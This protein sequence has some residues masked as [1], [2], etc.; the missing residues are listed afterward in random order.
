LNFL[1]F[2][3]P[4]KGI[5]KKFILIFA[6]FMVVVRS[7]A[8]NPLPR[9]GIASYY[10]KR[11]NHHRTASGERLSNDSFTAA[12]RTYPFGTYLKVTNLKNDRMTIV[13][14]NDRG[15]H[16]RRRII[17]LSYAAARKIR[18]MNCGLAEVRVELASDEEIKNKDQLNT[19][20]LAA[21]ITACIKPVK[22]V[23][24]IARSEKKYVI[25]AGIFRLKNSAYNLEKYLNHKNIPG[26]IVLKQNFKGQLAYKVTIGPLDT[27]EKETTLKLLR[28]KHIK[29]LVSSIKTKTKTKKHKR[30]HNE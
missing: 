9:N 25:Q 27:N 2:G 7:F 17:D 4:Q 30:R 1:I 21:D 6:A 11:S 19:D 8:G 29:G 20:S 28:A 14:I 22:T 10:G 16:R 3:I 24:E 5:M 15:P 12:Y 23:N 26:V 13:R 18:L